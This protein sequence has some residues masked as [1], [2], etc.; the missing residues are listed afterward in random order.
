MRTFLLALVLVLSG[1]LLPTAAVAADS[2]AGRLPGEYPVSGTPH[3][4][5]GR[6]Y[7]VA[8]VGGTIVLG[9]SF[10]TARNDGS[11]VQVTRDNLLA[12]DLGT[13]HISTTFVPNPNGDV[14]K[15]LAAP[16]GTSVFVAGSFT[17]IGGVARQRIARIRVSDGAVLS[18]F[19]AGG[20]TGIV[21]DLALSD[22]RLWL[23]GAF[24]HVGGHHQPALATVDPGSGS[25][26]PY[27]GLSIEGT[28]NG[29]TTQVM[30]LD[31]TPD[32]KTLVAIGNFHTLDGVVDHQLFT[33]DL[34]GSAAAPGPMGTDFY[35]STCSRRFDSYMRDVSISPDGTFFVVATTGAYNGS[36]S[37]C[38]TTARFE[39]A[40]PGTNEQ[41]S[42]VDY[43]GGDTT[44]AV[45]VTQSA[46]FVGGH[47]RWENNPFAGDR[48]GAGAVSREGIAA[49]DP[50]NGLPLSWN[51]GRTKGVGVFD[52]LS[53]PQGLWVGSDTDRIGHY[54]YRA[55]IALMPADGVRFPAVATPGLPNDV[56]SGGA[57]GAVD[58]PRV[59]YRV[60]AGGPQ[61]AAPTGPAWAADTDA[62][63]SPYHVS[64]SNRSSWG[65]V[66][67][68]DGTVPA[69]TPAQ[70]FDTEL[71]DPPTAPE[72]QW[73]F[74]VPA[75]TPI[76]VRLYFANRYSG[77]SQVGQRVFDVAIDGTTVLNNFDIVAAA[78]DQTGTMRSFDLT[79]DGNLDID[80]SHVV[81]NP[82]LDGVEIVR[83]DV[84]G[85]PPGVLT[86]RSFDGS[87]AGA[88]ESA[89]SGGLDWNTVHGA[90]MINGDLYVAD[91]GGALT[92]RPFDGT[93]YGA[94]TAVD[95]ADQLVPLADWKS[96]V[97]GATGM[98]YDSG[99]IY[100]TLAGSSD[101]Y[102]RYFTAE[103]GVVGAKRLVA[104]PSIAGVD[105]S[106][107]RGMFTTGSKLY[108]ATPDG[109]LHRADWAQ[110]P[111]S[112]AP[113]A[114][115]ATVVSGPG[116]D[117][118]TWGA[119]VLF[120][121]QGADGANGGGGGQTT[122]PTAAF[123]SDCTGLT[124]AF[125]ASASTPGSGGPLS[126]SWQL[127]DGANAS[128]ASPSH[129][130]SAGGTYTVSLTVTSSSGTDSTS[131]DVT[132]TAPN[133][134][135][136][137][138][139]TA[140]C[141]ALTCSFDASGS[142]DPD[143]TVA[144]YAWDFG[145]GSS[146]NGATASHTYGSSGQRTVTLTVTDDT[147]ATDTATRSV[148]PGTTTAPTVQFVAANSANASWSMPRV[149]VPAAVQPG[150]AL[151][152]YMAVNST[153]A[154]VTAP[155]GWTEIDS[156]D[157]TNVQ[158]RVWTRTATAADAG[159]DVVVALSKA[160]KS[161]LSVVAYRGSGADATVVAHAG[162]LDQ[163]S[164]TDHVA[165][166]V[167][168]T[169]AGQW[170]ATYWAEKSS[171]T[172]SW[173]T[174]AGQSV[175][176]QSAGSGGGAIAAVL[177][178]SAGPVPSGPFAGLTATTSTEVTRVVMFTTVIGLT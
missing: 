52:F 111:Q 79:S 103:S 62:N 57:S 26:T 29:G 10:S 40:D 165:P 42:W 162:A 85:P 154:T 80:L 12:F 74:P 104:S 24:T 49:L 107:V 128:G 3:V 113:V 53:T 83:T 112:G 87:T 1:A 33:L 22:G 44:Y 126:Y 88:V 84:A 7:S 174:P 37:A 147:G 133:Q 11:T 9:G 5:D 20:V 118:A 130:F 46:V 16:D 14:R 145:D 161:D 148:D 175:R 92:K 81:E 82:L 149:A 2:P 78:G 94:P 56:Y 43:T 28:N 172:V 132:V 54:S 115:S 58:D 106:Q 21:K 135:P 69:G 70:L 144:G 66:S 138:A 167:T 170:V 166:D 139:F 45:E 41:P 164:G 120:L 75:G 121:Y 137:A 96:D 30:K 156:L 105:F 141:S 140:S 152:L 89:P 117:A 108:W 72:Q 131:H 123:T 176:A 38:D 61:L 100:F 171:N 60:D 99:R 17:S 91:E 31:I 122:P 114:G 151:V 97:V 169:D 124:C 102:Y 143:G 125:D 155:S 8:Q 163:V 59:L 51:P 27:M 158:G 68:V 116:V 13:G 48:E 19:D 6:V 64:G 109:R 32:G 23:A 67:T 47:M 34:T 110:G 178:D 4:L 65:P 146:G 101:L 50:V 127:G 77:T 136:T 39:L 90:F 98:F 18:S 55:R 173:A 35:T 150:D 86:R 168:T 160:A 76:Q 134:P 93:T 36:S 73:S 177:V 63:P 129:T 25:W 157:G 153:A 159:S 71:W 15:V 142:D 119:H 95:T